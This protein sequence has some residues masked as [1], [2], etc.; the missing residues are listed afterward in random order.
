MAERHGFVSTADAL[1]QLLNAI[2]AFDT[3]YNPD[4]IFNEFLT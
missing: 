4:P 3:K 2:V 1:C